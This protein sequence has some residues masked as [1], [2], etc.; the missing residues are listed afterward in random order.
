MFEKLDWLE[1]IAEK[2]DRLRKINDGG[3]GISIG[4]RISD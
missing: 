2:E 1:D 4:E 3:F